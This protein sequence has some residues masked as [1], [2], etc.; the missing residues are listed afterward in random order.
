MGDV[1]N[2]E[3]SAWSFGGDFSP[4]GRGPISSA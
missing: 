1:P 3:V 4:I 2:H